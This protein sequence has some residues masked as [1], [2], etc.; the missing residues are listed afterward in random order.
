MGRVISFF[1]GFITRLGAGACICH[2]KLVNSAIIYTGLFGPVHTS[3]TNNGGNI[4]HVGFLTIFGTGTRTFFTIR[5]WVTTL[6]IGRGVGALYGR[7]F[8]GIGVG[9]I[10]LFHTWVT[11]QT[12]GRFGSHLGNSLT[13]LLG[14]FHITSAF[15]VDIYTR[16]GMGFVHMI[17]HFLHRVLTSGL[18]R[19]T[20]RL[21]KG[22]GFAIQGHA[23]S[24]G[25]YYSVTVKL[26]VRTFTYCYLK[27]FS[28]FG[29]FTF[30][31]CCGTFFTTFFG[32]F[33]Y[34][35]GANETYTRCYGVVFF[36]GFAVWGC[37][38]VGLTTFTFH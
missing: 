14:L 6:T 23:N 35:G 20:T 10:Y 17:G 19:V 5:G 36:R 12:I 25:S 27:T 1:G 32:R 24:K 11:G 29:K 8:F 34:N 30:F 2:T 7:V 22:Q 21:V 3:S 37:L 16:F 9:I 15:G 13:S 38:D 28:F 31:G 33:S 18:K 4:N 26:T